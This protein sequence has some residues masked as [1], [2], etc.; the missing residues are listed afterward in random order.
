MALPLHQLPAQLQDAVLAAKA[1][2]EAAGVDVWLDL[3]A[4]DPLADFPAHLYRH[5]RKPRGAGVVVGRLRRVRHLHAVNSASPGSMPGGIRPTW[6]GACGCSTRNLAADIIFAGE[7]N[8]S[9]FLTR[10]RR[11]A[12]RRGRESLQSRLDA[13]LSE[14]PLADERHAKPRRPSTSPCR[15]CEFTGRGAVS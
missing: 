15:A 13:L 12:K 11:A 6:R 14:G 2:L 1:A 9:N 10:P 3:E 7:L 8:V 5:R 4:I